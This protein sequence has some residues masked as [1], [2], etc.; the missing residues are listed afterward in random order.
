[1][2]KLGECQFNDKELQLLNHKSDWLEKR[3]LAAIA[4]F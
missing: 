1:M 4:E 3:K 2:V